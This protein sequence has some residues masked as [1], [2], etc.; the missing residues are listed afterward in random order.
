M[1]QCEHCGIPMNEDGREENLCVCCY[2]ELNEFNHSE[3]FKF[4][5]EGVEYE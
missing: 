1:R 2:I 3:D 4:K 5:T